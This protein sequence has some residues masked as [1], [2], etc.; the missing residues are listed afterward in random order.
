MALIRIVK[1]WYYRLCLHSIAD[2]MDE[3]AETG[4]IPSMAYASNC[5]E[6]ARDLRSKLAMLDV[7]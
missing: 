7:T 3:W 5:E 4:L 2:E 1:R 6:Q